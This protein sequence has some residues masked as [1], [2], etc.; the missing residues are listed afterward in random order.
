MEMFDSV[1]VRCPRCGNELEF[2]SKGGA[3]AHH[4]YRIGSV[5]EPVA[6]DIEGVSKICQC[7]ALVAIEQSGRDHISMSVQFNADETNESHPDTASAEP[8]ADAVRDTT[9]EPTVYVAADPSWPEAAWAACVDDMMRP[10]DVDRLVSEWWQKGA[11]VTCVTANQAAGMMARR[12]HRA[13]GCQR[14]RRKRDKRIRD[15]RPET[16][17]YLVRCPECGN[18][19]CPRALSHRGICTGGIPPF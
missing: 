13:C 5:P 4:V 15:E 8:A 10:E 12:Y 17:S 2:Q 1:Y 9:T 7:G 19:I 18:R 16:V 6:S 11:Y 3:C 14:C